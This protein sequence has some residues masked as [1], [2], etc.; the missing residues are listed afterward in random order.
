MRPLVLES[1]SPGVGGVT[2]S[3]QGVAHLGE[4]LA[5]E[6]DDFAGCVGWRP[7]LRYDCRIDAVQLSRLDLPLPVLVTDGGDLAGLD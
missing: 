6:G 2:L 1:L 4:L 3:L 5:Q 7:G